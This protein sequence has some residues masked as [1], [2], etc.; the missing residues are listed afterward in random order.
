MIFS[1]PGIRQITAAVT[2]IF[3]SVTGAQ[4]QGLGDILQQIEKNTPALKAA[5]A[6]T[7]MQQ[8]AARQARSGY[9]GEVDVMAKNSNYDDDRLINPISYPVNMQPELFDDNQIGYGIIGRIPLD[10][11]GRITAQVRAADRELEAAL[12]REDNVRLQMLH[13]A[14]DLYH[15]LEGVKALEKALEKQIEALQTHIQVAKVS[16]DAG[17]TA[18]VEKLRLVADLEAVRGKLAGMRG[19]EQG[20]RARL[21]ALMG[22]ESFADPVQPVPGPPTAA[23][24]VNDDVTGRPDIRALTSS[25]DAAEAEVDAAFARRLPDLNVNGSWLQN[26]GFDGDGDDTWALFVQF[27]VPLWDGGGRRAAVR[28]AEAGRTAIRHELDVTRNQARAEFVAAKADLAAAETSYRATEASVAAARETARIQTDRFAE[29]R[30]SASDL[31]DAE[32]ALAAARS[33]S[34]LALTRWWQ[35][36][37]HLRRAVGAE[38][39]AYVA[40]AVSTNN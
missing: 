6:R 20:I 16:I 35:A 25:G 28:R 19:Q 2:I 34:A 39:L 30:I 10:I 1:L 26:Q 4:S 40:P 17:R 14:A 27:Q 23:A 8:A 7:A 9:W 31:V 24:K 38:P 36:G 37:D 21:A 3:C 5:H 15:S 32:A 18:P 29:G 33:D 22:T 11:N 13:S 12:A